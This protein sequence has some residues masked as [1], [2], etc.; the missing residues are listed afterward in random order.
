MVPEISG[1]NIMAVFIK[2][3]I[4]SILLVFSF[5]WAFAQ[6]I[7]TEVVGAFGKGNISFISRHFDNVVSLS[8]TGSQASYSSS[9][10]EMI[11]KDFFSKNPPQSFTVEQ[12]RDGNMPYTIGILKTAS[13]NFRT[14]IAAKRK[15][16]KLLIQEI[17]LEK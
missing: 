4:G 12:S 10:A 15:D 14:Y 8:V 9:Q 1:G 6:G 16:G 17:R 2:K 11:L 7:I 3:I 5:S 13:G